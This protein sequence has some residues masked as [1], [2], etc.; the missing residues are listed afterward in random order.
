MLYVGST[1]TGRRAMNVGWLDG[2]GNALSF[3]PR[4]V[5]LWGPY[6]MLLLS[7]VAAS[8]AYVGLSSASFKLKYKDPKKA[9]T[10]KEVMENESTLTWT[11]D[12]VDADAV[13]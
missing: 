3:L 13:T 6:K 7:S 8:T 11:L 1:D 12:V 4:C 9:K 2:W 5:F 10:T